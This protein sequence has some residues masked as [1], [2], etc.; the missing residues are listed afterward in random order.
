MKEGTK[1]IKQ[2]QNKFMN[3]E[4]CL[5]TA[6]LSYMSEDP[7]VLQGGL[8]QEGLAQEASCKEKEQGAPGVHEMG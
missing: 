5:I 7:T 4:S 2:A 3:I 1:Y 8:H 6:H